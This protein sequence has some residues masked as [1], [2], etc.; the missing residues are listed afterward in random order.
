MKFKLTI[1]FR[2]DN[3]LDAR[4]AQVDPHHNTN[5]CH[6][7]VAETAKAHPQTCVHMS[8]LTPEYVLTGECVQSE[9]NTLVAMQTRGFSEGP[10]TT[11]ARAI[12][13]VHIMHGSD[14]RLEMTYRCGTRA[15]IFAHFTAR[16]QLSKGGRRLGS[17]KPCTSSSNIAHAA[18]QTA[19]PHIPQAIPLAP[20]QAVQ[21][22]VPEAAKTAHRRE[23]GQRGRGMVG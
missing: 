6:R 16:Q 1:C 3:I 4:R 19:P 8:P 5:T 10:A 7:P 15:L 13:A 9:S 20:G 22:A 12:H 14:V 21:H 11:A 2:K 23:R 18:S 17:R